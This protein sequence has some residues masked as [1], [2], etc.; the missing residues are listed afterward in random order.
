MNFDEPVAA[1]VRRNIRL[2][3]FID[4]TSHGQLEQEAA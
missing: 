1:P 2:T 4:G 3:Q